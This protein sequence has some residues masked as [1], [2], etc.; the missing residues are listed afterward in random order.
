M[1]HLTKQSGM[2]LV[3][4]ILMLLMISGIAVTV[5]SGSALDSKMVNASQEVYR[6]EGLI[7]GD[8]E[9]A[10]KMEIDSDA[11]SRFKHNR[12]RF[13]QGGNEYILDRN[14]SRIVLVNET[15]DPNG[16]F[17]QCPRSFAPT[18]NIE[19]NYLRMSA[20]HAYGKGDKHSLTVHSG[21]RQEV[22]GRGN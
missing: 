20:R 16:N 12:S 3:T 18:E 1:G 19:C 5:M 6:A 15:V 11:N 9:L 7:R 13:E 22:I 4:S 8:S 14:N 21:I 2:V 10:I 17:A